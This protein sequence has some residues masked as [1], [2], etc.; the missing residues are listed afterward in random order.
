MPT[1]DQMNVPMALPAPAQEE[2]N[3]HV[4]QPPHHN[5]TQIKHNCVYRNFVTQKSTK[6][7]WND[8]TVMQ[9]MTLS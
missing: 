5:C 3:D 7:G 4:A 9:K 2:F 1:G 6:F 8:E